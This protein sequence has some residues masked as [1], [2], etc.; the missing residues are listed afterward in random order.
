MSAQFSKRESL[1]RINFPLAMN[2]LL[3][4]YQNEKNIGKLGVEDFT[5]SAFIIDS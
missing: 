2:A 5:T 4:D 1:D 3:M